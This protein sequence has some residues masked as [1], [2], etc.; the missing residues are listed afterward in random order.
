MD[1]QTFQARR[2]DLAQRRDAAWK[3]L[4]KKEAGKKA[5]RLWVHAMFADF[6]D[7]MAGKIVGPMVRR[8]EALE[9]E[10]DR[11]RE[12]KG[13]SLA[14]VYR[15]SYERGAAYKRGELLTHNGNLWLAMKDN[16]T[17][18]GTTDGWRLIVKKGRDGRSR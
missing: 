4:Q 18:P 10:S 15:G 17:E 8:I 2:A 6:L 9:S 13:V 5:S 11:M 3:Q 1:E 12:S 14:D 16:N 7:R